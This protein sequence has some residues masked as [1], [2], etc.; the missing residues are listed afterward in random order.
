[1]TYK[2]RTG[3]ERIRTADGSRHRDRRRRE[4]EER[5]EARNKRTGDEQFTALDARQGSA[6]KERARLMTEVQDE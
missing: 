5:K 1:M 3:H 2:E 4:A 6:M